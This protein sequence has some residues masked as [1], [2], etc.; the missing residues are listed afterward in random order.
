MLNQCA[1]SRLRRL[2]RRMTAI[3]DRWLEADG[4][5]ISQYSLLAW[6]GR[7]GPI[8]NIQL[9]AE[10]GMQRSTLSR[11]LKPLLNAG[12]VVTVDLPEQAQCDKRSFGLALTPAGREKWD[13]AYPQWEKAQQEINQLLGDATQEQLIGVVNTA[14]EKL[15]QAA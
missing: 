13:A 5:T 10:M 2:T 6:I 11:N 14:Y 3:Y 9:A 12:W 4:L 15:Q 7:H 1:C 8:A